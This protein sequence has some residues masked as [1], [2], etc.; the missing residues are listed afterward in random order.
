MNTFSDKARRRRQYAVV[1]RG[2]PIKKASPVLW[3][4][5][6]EMQHRRSLRKMA[7]LAAGAYLALNPAVYT[8]T[9]EQKKPPLSGAVSYRRQTTE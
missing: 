9:L 7:I 5:S 2:F 8:K 3:E 6:Q 4:P 1:R